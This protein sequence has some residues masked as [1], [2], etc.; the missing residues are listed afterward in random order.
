ML[1]IRDLYLFVIYSN[2]TPSQ[3]PVQYKFLFIS[4]THF[5]FN[6]FVYYSCF[7]VAKLNSLDSVF[8]FIYLGVIDTNKQRTA[9]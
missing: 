1:T 5:T 8:L 6:Y 7:T 9:H 2:T 4:Y 3:R